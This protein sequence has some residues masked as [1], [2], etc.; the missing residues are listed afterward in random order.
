LETGD[1]DGACN[2]AYYAMFEAARFALAMAGD[3]ES[4]MSARTHR[5]MISA[6]GMSLVN[7]GMVSPHL[8]R[9]INRAHQVRVNADYSRGPVEKKAAAEL[10]N[11][12]A[13]FLS[14]I[15]LRFP[16]DTD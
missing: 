8:G 11:D 3:V 10:V 12:A 4:S 9:M 5:G 15:K 2:R 7:A 6:F 14:V 1:T 16:P 13:G